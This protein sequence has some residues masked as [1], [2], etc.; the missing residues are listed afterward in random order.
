MGNLKVLHIASLENL[1]CA[2][3]RLGTPGVIVNYGRSLR[4][5][6]QT[7]WAN[8]PAERGLP[9]GR[10]TSERQLPLPV[11]LLEV[12]DGVLWIFDTNSSGAICLR[13]RRIERAEMP[14]EEAVP[15]G[16]FML[17][18]WLEDGPKPMEAELDQARGSSD[19]RQLEALTL[20][21]GDWLRAVASNPR[22][23][24]SLLDRL[25]RVPDRIT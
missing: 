4:W 10:C 2:P 12:I 3:S 13:N 1:P 20:R 24:S 11:P 7:Y 14:M 6:Q 23:S 18:A 17:R 21:G 25:A 8:T 22:A 15:L 19:L 9:A 16:P 5:I